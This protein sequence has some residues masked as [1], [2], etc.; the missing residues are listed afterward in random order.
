MCIYNYLYILR[1]KCVEAECYPILAYLRVVSLLNSVNNTGT[2]FP[3][4]ETLETTI[5]HITEVWFAMWLA[6]N[7]FAISVIYHRTPPF[8]H[9]G[10]RLRFKLTAESS[11]QP[12]GW[13]MPGLSFLINVLDILVINKHSG[14]STMAVFL[15]LISFCSTNNTDVL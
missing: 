15:I 2:Y 5:K 14:Q 3:V 1:D 13:L 11:D 7:F 4:F 9:E 12:T 6:V 10:S 8:W